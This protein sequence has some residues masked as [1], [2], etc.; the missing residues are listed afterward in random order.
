[1]ACDGCAEEKGIERAAE[2][3]RLMG[4]MVQM[5]DKQN[6]RLWIALLACVACLV[7]MSG[8]MIWTVQNAQ[9][10]AN[11]AMANA[12]EAVAEI[13]VTREETTTTV[14]QDTGEGIGNNVY[15]QENG[16]YKEDFERNASSKTLQKQARRSLCWNL[17]KKHLTTFILRQNP[18]EM[19][20]HSDSIFLYKSDSLEDGESEILNLREDILK[21]SFSAAPHRGGFFMSSV[22]GKTP[23][24]R[25]SYPQKEG[26]RKQKS[27]RRRP[28]FFFS[29]WSDPMFNTFNPY[30]PYPPTPFQPPQFMPQQMQPQQPAQA[31]N[32]PAVLQVATIKQVEQAPVQ[33]GGKALVLVANEPVIAMRTADSMGITTTDYYHIERFD[34]DAA[35]A[36]PAS[37]YV[38][39][40]EFQQT[41]QQ[42]LDNMQKPA[43]TKKEAMPE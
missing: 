19:T 27:C 34:P 25:I 38:T 11:E 35:Q 30:A 28:P 36:A 10:I 13:G 2:S 18:E 29:E 37:D 42:L 12:L 21:Q 20:F 22:G 40:Q 31:Q 16:T 9:R 26:D 43:R 7:I 17:E 24:N 41:I 8:C 32:T 1:M 14:T 4:D 5:Y 15:L 39:R 3:S 33:P 6:R 23:E